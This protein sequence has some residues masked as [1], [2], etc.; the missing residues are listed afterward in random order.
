[1]LETRKYTDCMSLH[2]RNKEIHWTACHYML[3]TM[4]YTDC[5]TLHAR[6]K[7]LHGLHVTTC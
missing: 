2:A 5:M 7:E 1:M 6:N 3:E 4:E